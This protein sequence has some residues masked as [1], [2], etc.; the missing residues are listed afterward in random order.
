MQT[1]L[2]NKPELLYELRLRAVQFPTSATA[3]DL[4]QLLNPLLEQPCCI[5]ASPYPLEQDMDEVTKCL[6][7]VSSRLLLTSTTN[8][9]KDRIATNL[10]HLCARINRI[11]VSTEDSSEFIQQYKQICEELTDCQKKFNS[12][13]TSTL[14]SNYESATSFQQPHTDFELLAQKLSNLADIRQTDFKQF[15]YKGDGCPRDFIQKVEEFA[16][17]RNI[18]Q[19]RLHNRIFDLLTGTALDWYRAKR[20]TLTDWKTFKTQFIKDF[21]IHDHDFYLSQTINSRKQK[22]NERIIMFFSAMEAL[23][24]K[25]HEPLSE[26]SKINILRRN[27]NPTYSSKLLPTDIAS[28]DQ[29]FQ[30]C[31]WYESCNGLS[32]NNIFE[33]NVS[34]QQ[35]TLNYSSSTRPPQIPPFP[36]KHEIPIHSL[37]PQTGSILRFSCPRCRTN[38]HQLETCTSKKIICFRC[39][40]ENVTYTKCNNCHKHS[41]N[42]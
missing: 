15:N 16:I 9:H 33:Q 25:L 7:T 24:S 3:D 1:A 35:K 36:F 27:M 29:L 21:E 2:L 18:D 20:L 26:Q 30:A 8:V 5:E 31:K 13:Q 39:G 28:I 41:K 11:S 42:A 38:D 32:Q 4:R 14:T 23:F 37:T 10:E 34:D 40:K 12:L 17:S 22:P 19:K 6:T